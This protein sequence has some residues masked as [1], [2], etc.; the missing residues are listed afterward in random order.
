METARAKKDSL[1]K[2]HLNLETWEGCE[3]RDLGAPTARDGGV[4]QRCPL[5]EI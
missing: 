4:E 1:A 2:V 5:E 3:R